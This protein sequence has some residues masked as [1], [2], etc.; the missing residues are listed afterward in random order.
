M[1][2]MLQ[3]IADLGDG[4]VL[5]IEVQHGLPFAVEIEFRGE[6]DDGDAA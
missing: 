1:I 2:E 3:V 5:A 4:E 6:N